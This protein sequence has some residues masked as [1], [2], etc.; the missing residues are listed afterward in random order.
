MIWITN[1]YHSVRLPYSSEL[2]TWLTEQYPH[3]DYH[4]ITI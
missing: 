4:T 1:R 2:L 3:S